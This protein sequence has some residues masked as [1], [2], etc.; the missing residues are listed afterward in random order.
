VKRPASED[1]HLCWEALEES[2]G[3]TPVPPG[4]A[5]GVGFKGIGIVVVE[6]KGGRGGKLGSGCLEKSPPICL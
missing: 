4:G 2:T 6:E 5:E 3:G 1:G